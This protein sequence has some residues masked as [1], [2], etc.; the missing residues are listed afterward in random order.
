MG[1]Q[2]VKGYKFNTGTDPVYEFNPQGDDASNGVTVDGQ[3]VYIANGTDGL[4]ITTIARSGNKDPEEVY[5]W[6]SGSGSANFVKTDG[7]F[8]I[9]AN[10]TDGLN[11]LRKDNK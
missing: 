7:K 11:I 2:G 3:Y 9:L 6:K 1:D 10:G 8:I 5:G 4:F